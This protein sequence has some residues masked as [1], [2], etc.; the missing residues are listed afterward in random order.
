[1]SPTTSPRRPENPYGGIVLRSRRG[2]VGETW[3]GADLRDRL[4]QVLRRRHATTGRRAA[5]AGTVQQGLDIAPGRVRAV[6]AGT[7][8]QRGQFLRTEIGFPVFG[9]GDLAALGQVLR[10]MPSQLAQLLAGSMPPEL[11]DALEAQLIGLLPS[12][13]DVTYDCSCDVFMEVCEHVGALAYVLIEQVDA[14]PAVLL[15]LRGADPAALLTTPHG[16]E[17]SAADRPAASDM[18]TA[19]RPAGDGDVAGTADDSGAVTEP[20]PTEDPLGA[21]PEAPRAWD[22]RAVDVTGLREL[23][24]DEAADALASFYGAPGAHGSGDETGGG[25]ETGDG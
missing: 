14:E 3:W 24:G 23:L 12:P 17:R 25:D 20:G 13:G 16:D 18:P 7:G 4:E 6:V 8:E 5:R 10:A 22:P 11:H 21:G 15:T 1:M 2:D 19:D 9:R